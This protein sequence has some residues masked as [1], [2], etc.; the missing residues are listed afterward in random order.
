MPGKYIVGRNSRM[1]IST[2]SDLT[3]LSTSLLMETL[4]EK[5]TSN[6][7][8]SFYGSVESLDPPFIIVE[9][10]STIRCIR[11]RKEKGE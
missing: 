5:I 8:V 4:S 11:F 3:D 9:A 10:R 6:L 1:E 2:P 7:D